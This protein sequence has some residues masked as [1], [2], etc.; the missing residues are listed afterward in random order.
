MERATAEEVRGCTSRSKA[1]VEE[2]T[3]RAQRDIG[4]VLCGAHARRQKSYGTEE[5][6][7]KLARWGRDSLSVLNLDE[8][9]SKPTKRCRA[10]S[11]VELK[12]S[13]DTVL[14]MRGCADTTWCLYI[15]IFDFSG[16][17]VEEAHRARNV[18]LGTEHDSSCE[19]V[20]HEE[21]DVKALGVQLV[22]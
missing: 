12:T 18:H 7:H 14:W 8:R 10:R 15:Y 20:A 4:Q 1:R 13:H 9:A 5:S 16:E 19:E 21:L 22:Y 3:R 6:E 11:G 17:L 2:R